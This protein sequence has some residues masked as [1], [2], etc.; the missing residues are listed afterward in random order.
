MIARAMTDA[1]NIRATLD[2]SAVAGA[3]GAYLVVIA[4]GS[5]SLRP[6]PTAGRVT[7]GRAPE[8]EL[9]IDDGAT[10]RRHAAFV[11]DGGAVTVE[12]LGSH[13]GTLVNGE[14]LTRPRPLAPGDAVTV[15]ETLLVLRG[16]SR[17]VAPMAA[18]RAHFLARLDVEAERAAEFGRPLGLVALT[19]EAPPRDVARVTRAVVGALR[20]MDLVAWEGDR[21]LLALLPERDAS[22]AAEAA[23]RIAEAAS[24]AGAVGRAGHASLPDDGCDGPSLRGAVLEAAAR[25]AGEGTVEAS[26]RLAVG[27][28][29]VLVA[30]PAMTRLYAL[31]RRLAASDLPVLVAGETGAGKENAAYAVHAWSRRSAGPFVPINCAA[32]PENLVESELFG[33]EKGAFSG[34]AGP[35]PGLLET[36]AGGTVFLDELGELSLAVQAKLLRVLETK[37]VTRVGAVRDREVDLRVVAATHRDLEEEVRRGRFREDLFFRLGAAT[38]VLPP[39]RDR[40]REVPLL[41]RAFLDAACVRAGR[42]PLAPTAALL[43]FLARYRWPGNVRELK[44]AMDYAAAAAEG[45]RVDVEHLPARIAG[46]RDLAPPPAPTPS[47]STEGGARR[48]RPLAE[49]LHELERRRIAEA[50]EATGYVQTRAAELLSMP[51]RTFIVKLKGYGI[52]APEGHRRKA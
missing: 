2:V 1:S 8:C 33:H 29:T 31:I 4:A 26:S 16:A 48:F 22:G 45:D 40:P 28:R 23:A 41:A 52:E 18:E 20:R 12:D 11:V 32:I 50:Y 38:V 9:R 17:G 7:V 21:A 46:A 25:G 13:N 43:R 49:E 6:L 35:K 44:H 3:G 47:A 36:A 19:F 5:S 34:A 27:E 39:L 15:G 24:G 37:R 30:D 10:S 14:R 51:L 42:G